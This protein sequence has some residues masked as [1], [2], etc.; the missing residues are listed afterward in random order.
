VRLAGL[1]LALLLSG[2]SAS[3]AASQERIRD[4]TVAGTVPVTPLGP[5]EVLLELQVT[6]ISRLPGDVATVAV[7]VTRTGSTAAEAR[8]A[9]AS[10]TDRIAAAA[11]KSG[12][13]AA[14]IR[15]SPRED[16]RIAFVSEPDPL[17]VAE[18][19]NSLPKRHSASAFVQITL[20]DLGRYESLRRS[21]ET[22]QTAVPLP[23]YG[24]ADPDRGKREARADAIRRARAEA[25]DYAASIGMRVGRFIRVSAHEI[26]DQWIIMEMM[27]MASPDG[28]PPTSVETKISLSADFA[29]VASR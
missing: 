12:L 23:V 25:E 2:G 21:I 17:M 1:I 24:L 19:A 27:R 29:L 13:A 8:A 7:P 28:R 16:P 11:R 14:D 26:P 5:D 3:W 22:A 10:E 20:R 9:L 15:V 6:G 18:G 4:L